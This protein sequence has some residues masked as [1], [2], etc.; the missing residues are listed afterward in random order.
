MPGLKRAKF[1]KRGAELGR[2]IAKG[3]QVDEIE[4]LAARVAIRFELRR[5]HHLAATV[6]VAN[7]GRIPDDDRREPFRE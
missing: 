2:E 6:D 3:E 7:L 4:T 1:S 5:D